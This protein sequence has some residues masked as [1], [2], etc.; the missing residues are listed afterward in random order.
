M[1]INSHGIS[2]HT[3][4]STRGFLSGKSCAC[5]SS[6][7]TNHPSVDFLVCSS[8]FQLKMMELKLCLYKCPAVASDSKIYALIFFCNSVHRMEPLKWEK[9]TGHSLGLP[10]RIVPKACTLPSH[11]PI[12]THTN[13]FKFHPPLSHSYLPPPP[14]CYM[15]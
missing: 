7:V 4:T 5:P 15:T 8:I 10:M 12:H 2:N 13:V 3:F 1:S 9:V 14:H 6:G 11:T